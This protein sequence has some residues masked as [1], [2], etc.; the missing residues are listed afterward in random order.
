MTPE[1]RRFLDAILA[2]P[3]DDQ[4]RLAYADWLEENGE[5]ERALCIRY[6]VGNPKDVY[7][8][9]CMGDASVGQFCPYW[10]EDKRRYCP[11]CQ[12]SKEWGVPEFFLGEATSSLAG[13]CVWR[14]GFISELRGPLASLLDHGPAILREHPVDRVEV[15]DL[16]GHRCPICDS[17]GQWRRGVGF[18]HERICMRPMHA[19]G[20]DVIWEPANHAGYDV[21]DHVLAELRRR[22][23]QPGER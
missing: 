14:R 8:N 15:T 20:R 21:H 18:E 11:T 1:R 7:S 3:E 10:D 23:T 6:Q 19:A 13:T 22:A 2:A 5:E 17:P 9:S 4:P 16:L 12:V